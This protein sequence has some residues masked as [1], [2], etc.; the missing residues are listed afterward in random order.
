MSC[1]INVIWKFIA[2]PRFGI[3]Y[4]IYVYYHKLFFTFLTISFI[5][6]HIYIYIN[7]WFVFYSINRAF[8]VL[9]NNQN[10]PNSKMNIYRYLLML[11]FVI[12]SFN[13][14]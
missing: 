6:M 2:E 11:E 12:F 5:T 13:I 3:K 9:I 7:I 8:V 14:T 10:K 4:L 1:Y